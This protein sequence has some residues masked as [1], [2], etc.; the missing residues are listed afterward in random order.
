MLKG[1][2]PRAIVM[3]MAFSKAFLVMIS[4]GLISWAIKYLTAS[5]ALRHSSNFPGSSAGK[6]ELGNIVL[7]YR[8]PSYKY[9]EAE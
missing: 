7:S 4:V 3:A 9:R 5:P 2:I 1:D 6:D 8:M